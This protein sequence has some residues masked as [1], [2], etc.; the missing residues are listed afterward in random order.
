M[1][2]EF[3]GDPADAARLPFSPTI[4]LVTLARVVEVRVASLL[5]RHG[6]T[7]R[8]YRLLARVAATPGISVSDLG[9]RSQ[10]SADAVRVLLKRLVDA[11]W[12][13]SPRGTDQVTLTPAGADLATR[14]GRDIADLDAELLDEPGGRELAEALALSE[15]ARRSG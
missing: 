10:D 5:E 12:V 7:L 2:D 11:G 1:P 15:T 13:T 6:L 8:G 9:R 14:V 4:A 3:D